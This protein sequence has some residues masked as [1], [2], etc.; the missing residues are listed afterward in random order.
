MG[1]SGDDAGCPARN[2]I[3]GDN[4]GR[5]NL[6]AVKHSDSRSAFLGTSLSTASFPG[7]RLT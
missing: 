3:E 7:K 4:D 5:L 6:S 2:Y 1:I